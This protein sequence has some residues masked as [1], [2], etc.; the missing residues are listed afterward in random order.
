MTGVVGRHTDAHHGHVLRHGRRRATISLVGRV[1]RRGHAPVLELRWHAIVLLRRRIGTVLRGI[2]LVHVIHLLMILRHVLLLML[3]SSGASSCRARPVHVDGHA[4]VGV[5]VL[6][7][8]Q[9][10][11]V[12]HPAGV[13]SMLMTPPYLEGLRGV[14]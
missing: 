1:S 11:A 8:R 7:S 12:T 5:Y 6:P 2:I 9:M 3:S 14:G 4:A 13:G 10:V